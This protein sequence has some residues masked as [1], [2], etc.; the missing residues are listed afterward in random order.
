M[1]VTSASNLSLS[2]AATRYTTWLALAV[3]VLVAVMPPALYFQFAQQTIQSREAARA[4]IHA[5]LVTD[6]VG[7][8]PTMWEFETLRLEALVITND[9]DE[10]TAV[11][12]A[13]GENVYVTGNLDIRAPVV[14]TSSP[15]YDSGV[16]VGEVFTARSLRSTLFTTLII[17]VMTASLA[18]L[19][20][21]ALKI[22]PLRLLKRA[23]D[24]VTFLASHDP[25]TNL[26]NRALFNEWL[27]HSVREVH[28][29]EGASM[30]VLYLDLDNFKDVNDFNGHPAG[31]KLLQEAAERMN[32]TLRGGDV[33]ARLGGDEF[34]IIHK[35]F[36]EPNSTGKLAERLLEELSRPFDIHGSEIVIGVS[37]GI[38][39]C[40]EPGERTA[41][42]VL[43]EA[44]MALYQAK[45]VGRGTFRYFEVKMNDK[46]IARKRMEND[47]RQAISKN[48]LELHYQPQ[49]N[50]NTNT[51]IGVEALIRWNHGQ[52]GLIMPDKFIPLAEETGLIVP[53]GDWVIRQA[54]RQA[55]EWPDLS[56]AVNISPVQIRQGNLVQTVR[57][58]LL[59]ENVE[60]HRLELEI[61]E[62]VLLT[63]T[64]E[65]IRTLRS[66]QELGIK[67][68]LDDF[69]TGYSSLSYL[70]R[71]PFDKIKIDKTF[72]DDLGTGEDSTDII[73]A[74]VRLSRALRM[75]STVEGVETVEQA[76][77]LRK[78]GCDQIQGY[79]ISKPLSF[80]TMKAYLLA[81]RLKPA[82][83]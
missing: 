81:Q 16:A 44:D 74:V 27:E 31:D 4:E 49:L 32:G 68:A 43:R 22:L 73:D 75:T 29:G 48:E 57:N 25:L 67:I 11:R 14:T 76:A 58:A 63:N 51:V 78:L 8:N 12:N 1:G 3:S 38:A 77:M 45:N 69:G 34:A 10:W 72:T 30:A 60:P 40:D 61:T 42:D 59:E 13:A 80:E 65:T 62:G 64:V 83:E 20:F 28:R 5:R 19:A 18:V 26:P 6:L 82:A 41:Q 17:F 39:V 15:I 21:L 23:T 54:C 79:L 36:D 46:L 24:R 56:I 50:S 70:R 7:A 37:I 47:L 66:L 55:A 71:F 2:P 35:H 9:R 33:V 52:N 53:I